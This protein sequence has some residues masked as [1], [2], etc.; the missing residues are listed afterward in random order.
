MSERIPILYLAPWVGYGGSDKNTI[1]WFRWID[2]DRFAPSLITTQ[3][4]PNPLIDEVAPFAEEVWVLPDLMPAEEMPRFILDFLQSRDIRVVHLMNS[5]IGFDLLPDFSCLPNP[6]SVVVQLHVEEVDRSGYVRY[7]TTRYG[8]LVDRFSISNE[9]VASAVREYGVSADKV[10]V[11]YTG[12]DAED[13]FSPERASPVEDLADDRLQILFAARLVPQKD[14]L[15]MV[16]VATELRDRGAKFQIQVVGEGDL[17]EQVKARVVE[18]GLGDHVVLHPMTAGLRDWYAA[19]DTLL[20]TSEFEGVPCVLF[21][22]MAMGLPIVAP[23]LPAIRELLDA[24]SDGL[25][26]QRDSA[27]AYAEPLQHLAGDR[28]QRQ[29]VGRAM[30]ERAKEQFSVQQMATSHEA[31]YTALYGA[32]EKPEKTALAPLPEPL[33]FPARPAAS[34]A[35]LV[36][37]L[38]PHFNQAGFLAEC[39]DSIQAQTYPN[40]EVVVVDDASTEAAAVTEL[41]ELEARDGVTVVR[42]SKNG[43]P[44]HARNVG[45]E[46]CSGR[47][48]LPVDSDNLL[49]PDAVEQLVDQL[50]AASKEIGF[51]YPN[52]EYFGNREDYYEVPQ[53]NLYTLLFGN[54]CDTCSLLDREIFDAG[55][56]YSEAIKL[57]H[58]DWEF[59]LRLA[60]HGIRGEAARGRTVRYRKWGF[61]RSDLVDHAPND[62]RDD[63]LSEISLFRGREAEIK[64]AEAPSLSVIALAATGDASGAP[65]SERA[66]AQLCTDFELIDFEDGLPGALELAHGAFVAVTSGSAASLF[67][68][69]SFTEKVLRRFTIAGSDLD[70]IALTDAGTAG[71]FDFRTLPS[72]DGPAE[73]VP[74]TVIWRRGF[75]QDLPQGLQADPAAPVTSIA[76]LLSGAGA[77]LEWRHLRLP[78]QAAAEPPVSSWESMPEDEASAEDPR[79]LRPAAQ[80]L[81]PGAGKYRV[82]RWDLTPTWVPPL[83][84]VAIRYKERVGD[85]RLTT[86]GQAPVDFRIEHFLG[87]LRSSGFQGT[88]KVVHIDGEYRAIPREEWAETPDEADEIGYAELAQ[89]PGMTVLA[90]A[91]HRETGEQVLVNLPDDPLLESADIVE[92]LGCLDPFP[93]EPLEIPTALRPLG[94]VG[95]AKA[96]DYD[97]RRHRYAIG[98]VP[99]GEFL[100]EVGGLGE[101][102]LQGT[103][104]AWIVDGYLVTERH[105][106]PAAKP[107]YVAAARWAGEPA[108]WGGLAPSGTRA[109]AIAKRSGI[110]ALKRLGGVERPV[111]PTGPPA[112]WMFELSRPGL[113]PVFAAY[114][115]VTGDQLLTRT[116]IS[117]AHLGYG[118]PELLGFVCPQ[119]PLTGE[120]DE[121]PHPIP[122]A[123]RFGAVPRSG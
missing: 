4:S 104:P 48:I 58:E 38:I 63:V 110:A 108:A 12:A 2:R 113:E 105:Q 93:L 15:L 70:A 83:S 20:L 80:P 86:N 28:E 49:L 75:E 69:P 72:N 101:S 52:I 65:N 87:A 24:E 73:P 61:N 90:M 53:Y 94:M 117:A 50:S 120:L 10:E 6:P 107:S 1:D 17:E 5:R 14:P 59:V 42:L 71:R 27:L 21:E 9:H 119:A 112:G 37:V 81:L 18:R 95:L 3:P 77:Q 68:D 62:F 84:T 92:T 88:T 91:I 7:V 54:F 8:N 79:G 56:H 111:K 121:R 100:G 40:L 41:D 123:R 82:P 74:H 55:I 85:R 16:D 33:R 114:H 99:E 76:R 97:G 64:A 23:A 44:S 43:G 118:E 66:Q 26:E 122:W 45:L 102:E 32:Q 30:R 29:A 35:P 96:L 67:A 34:T 13:E 98:T 46:S 36:S 22:A 19:T 115:P 39:L 25:I 116:A 89:L 51:V 109:K 103:I 60:A 78:E 31:I 11:I 47:Y 57:G 106:P